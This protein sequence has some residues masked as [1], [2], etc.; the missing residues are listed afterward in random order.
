LDY[1]LGSG[2]ALAIQGLRPAPGA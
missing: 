1:A 2:F